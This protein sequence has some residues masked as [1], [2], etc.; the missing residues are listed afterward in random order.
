MK[1]ERYSE[2][3]GELIKMEDE[4]GRVRVGERERKTG[5]EG[6]LDGERGRI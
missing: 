5:R 3:E 6:E 4:R 1:R 2:S